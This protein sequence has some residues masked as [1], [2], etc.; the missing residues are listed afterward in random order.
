[1]SRRSAS[2]GR[3]LLHW[4]LEVGCCAPVPSS[5]KLDG[6]QAVG[7]LAHLFAA[8]CAIGSEGLRVDRAGQDLP[9]N[10]VGL[11]S[12][13]TPTPMENAA[14][15][16]ARLTP[17]A[18]PPSTDRRVRS[19]DTRSRRA[20]TPTVMFFKPAGLWSTLRAMR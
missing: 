10:R 9:L 2:R 19:A 13:E 16:L 15:N 17:A 1:M 8:E 18:R 5:R 6:G 3:S 4:R 11:R 12:A 7:N 20:L 14:C